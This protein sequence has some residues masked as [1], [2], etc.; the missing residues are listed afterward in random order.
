MLGPQPE[1]TKSTMTVQNLIGN[2]FF[3]CES[4]DVFFANRPFWCFFEC[5]FVLFCSPRTGKNL[6]CKYGEGD[7]VISSVFVGQVCVGA[8][9]LTVNIGSVNT[10]AFDIALGLP[11]DS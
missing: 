10:A 2:H 1:L 5:H 3:E 8:V 4:S 6:A 7:A 11:S 9:D